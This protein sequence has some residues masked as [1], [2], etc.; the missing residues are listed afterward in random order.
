MKLP[1]I[2]RSTQC[3]LRI[4]QDNHRDYVGMYE[5]LSV[6]SMIVYMERLTGPYDLHGSQSKRCLTCP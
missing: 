6:K 5:A 1:G 2:S 3:L 4:M